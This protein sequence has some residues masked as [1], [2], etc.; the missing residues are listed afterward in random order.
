MMEELCLAAKSGIDVRIVTPGIPDKKVVYKLTQSYYP[1]LLEAGVRIYHY[2]PGF[3]HAKSYI[4]DDEIGVVGTINMDYRSLY[5]HF[6]C[7]TYMYKADALKNLK[8]DYLETFE[9]GE[10]VFL[11]V[12]T[13]RKSAVS[14][15]F[16]AVLRLFAPL[17]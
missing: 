4:C 3:I 7:A 12:K 14:A 17:M 2:T 11:E 6:E 16:K 8:Q 13:V 1:Q 10:E 15:L 9:K 5:L